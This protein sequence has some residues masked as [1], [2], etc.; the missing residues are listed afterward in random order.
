MDGPPAATG[1]RL[2]PDPP[3]VGMAEMADI[4][5]VLHTVS[6]CGLGPAA[7]TLAKHLLTYFQDEVN[8]HQKG[9]C[10]AGECDNG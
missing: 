9:R 1:V 10:P 5:D 8:A 6:A 3:E 4:I 2:K 7:G